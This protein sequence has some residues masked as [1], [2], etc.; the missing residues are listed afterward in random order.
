[1]EGIWAA[2][3]VSFASMGLPVLVRAPAI[4]QLLE[5]MPEP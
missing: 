1:M 3:W 2:R 4:T 5:P